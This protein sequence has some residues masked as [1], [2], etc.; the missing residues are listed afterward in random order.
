[1]SVT[2]AIEVR[3]RVVG[4]GREPLVCT[5]LVGRTREAILAELD[6]VTGKRPD[7]VEW[8][9]DFFDGLADTAGVLALARELAS[10]AGDIP[11]IFT[12]RSSRE[13]GEDIALGEEQ[14]AAL[15]VAVCEAQVAGLVD[16]EMSAPRAHLDRVREAA[17]ASDTRLILSY[18]N[19]RETPDAEALYARFSEAQLLGGDIAKVAVMPLGA[20]D[21]LTLLAATIRARRTL[22]LPLISIS[23]G[24]YGALTRMVGWMFGSSVTF[25]VGQG[26]SAPGQVPIEDLKAVLDILR[27]ALAGK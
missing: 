2:R 22:D 11:V 5:P 15:V 17:R 4:D 26:I 7:L 3:G 23:M 12:I 20:E 1:V 6:S 19:F 25:A 21:V 24:A 18:H 27:R 9:A 16:F 10:R 8:R 14:V 13:G